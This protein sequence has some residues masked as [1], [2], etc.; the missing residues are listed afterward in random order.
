[1]NIVIPEGALKLI[2]GFAAQI[3]VDGF[4]TKVGG[5]EVSVESGSTIDVPEGG[6]VLVLATEPKLASTPEPGAL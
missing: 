6:V 2:A 3:T 4:T 5:F 1:M